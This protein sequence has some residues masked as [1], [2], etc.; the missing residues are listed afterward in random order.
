MSNIKTVNK[1][2]FVNERTV[3]YGDMMISIYTDDQY[4][5]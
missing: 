4:I 1:Q 5:Y 2:E 3:I